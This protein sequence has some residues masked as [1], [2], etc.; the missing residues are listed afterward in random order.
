MIGAIVC[1]AWLTVHGVA[2]ADR[3][4]RWPDRAGFDGFEFLGRR[5]ACDA[6]VVEHLRAIPGRVQI[7][8][9]CGTGEVLPA[10]PVEYSWPGRVAAFS[11]RPGV[12][13]WSR[14]VFQFSVRTGADAYAGPWSWVRFREYEKAIVLALA[15]ASA[16]VPQPAAA[17]T[18]RRFG[19]TQVVAGGEERRLFRGL[20]AEA[21]ATSLGGRV[22]F[23]TADGCGVVELPPSPASRQ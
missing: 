22:S 18:L 21:L 12:C 5:H 2:A 17:D 8:E 19:V 20:T 14:H 9:L 6:A 23:A 15:S 3:A 7:G 1:G 13:G 16:K 10:I 4:L 11:G